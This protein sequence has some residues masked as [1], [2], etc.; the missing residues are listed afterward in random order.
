MIEIKQVEID[1]L[2]FKY[3]LKI[4][5]GN[6]LILY[7]EKHFLSVRSFYLNMYIIRLLTLRT[8]KFEF[9][10]KPFTRIWMHPSESLLQLRLS[11]SS[12]VL[13]SSALEIVRA[14]RI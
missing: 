9:F 5:K 12:V 11:S 10:F 6:Q 7:S 2:L 3:C 14:P 8:F 4:T 13:I 1:K